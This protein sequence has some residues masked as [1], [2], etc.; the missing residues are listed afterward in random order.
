MLLSELAA[1]IQTLSTSIP[2]QNQHTRAP[3][4]QQVSGNAL[5]V[6]DFC[7]AELCF[8]IK[9]LIFLSLWFYYLFNIMVNQEPT[10]LSLQLTWKSHLLNQGQLHFSLKINCL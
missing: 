6:S 1:C 10:L 3:T 7:P 9:I 8:E 2:L 4:L 5:Y